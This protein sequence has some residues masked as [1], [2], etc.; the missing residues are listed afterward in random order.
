MPRLE[1][2]YDPGGEWAALYVDGELERLGDAY[3]V[4]ARVFELAG[5]TVVQDDAFLRGQNGE[6]GVAPTLDDV[7]AYRAEREEKR[8]TAERLRAEAA[9]LLADAEA[10][11]ARPTADRSR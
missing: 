1:I 4:E 2:H 5:V 8:A 11:D 3:L 9:R 10:L 7:A 6:T